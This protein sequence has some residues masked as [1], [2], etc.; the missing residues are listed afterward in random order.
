[1]SRRRKVSKNGRQHPAPKSGARRPNY[2]LLGLALI[3]LAT[4][5]VY[6]PA[7]SGGK[8]IDD[9]GNITPPGLRSIN[10]LYHIWFDPKNTAQ[11][12]PL[13]HTVFWIEHRLWGDSYWSYHLVTLLWHAANV[14]LIYFILKKLRVPGALLAAAFFAL[15]PVIV[16]SVAWMCEQKNTLSTLFYL[17]AMSV[18]LRFD[19]S[20]HP[21]QYFAGLGLFA[22]ALLTKTIT[23]TLPIA[24]LLIFWWQRGTLSW[25]RDVLPLVTFFALGIACG[26]LTV[27]VEQSYFHGEEA[28]F[29]LTP[30]QR[31]LFAGRGIWF[32]LSKLIWPVNLYFTYP[33]WT[34][35]PAQWWQWIY[36]VAAL[37]TTIFLWT[38][39]N[40]WRAP[41]A[42]WLFFCVTLLPGIGLANVYMFT[43]TFVA[44]HMQYL[45]CLGIFVLAAAVLAQG[46]AGLPKSMRWSGVAACVVLVGSLAALSHQQ[47]APYGDAVTYYRML[48]A[49]NPDS[50]LAENNLGM[51]LANRGHYREA[52]EHYRASLRLKPIYALAHRNLGGL[53]SNDRR[54]SEA[55]KEF[56]IA[57]EIAPD[58]PE[59]LYG[60]GLA[61][62]QSGQFK[63]AIEQLERAVKLEPKYVDAHNILGVTLGSA[64]MTKKAI[65]EF[66][67]VLE[68]NSNNADAHNNWGRVL[69]DAGDKPA[70][71]EH[72]Q[73]AIELNPNNASFHFNLASLLAETGLTNDAIT[74]FEQAVRLQPG[75][76]EA[77]PEL[78]KALNA[79]GRPNDAVYFAQLGIAANRNAGQQA[80][81]EQIE[82]WLRDYQQQLERKR[83]T[84]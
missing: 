38:I 17:G 11:Y 47:S 63:E 34:I 44:D 50:W 56:R 80:A 59:A 70:A 60:L 29:T 15:H 65:A 82:K 25:R 81:A 69:A 9:E 45:A 71:I 21:A 74:H 2:E 54:F 64:G 36:P 83:A 27:F 5:W 43:I 16:E 72:F 32:Y 37:V 52:M 49:E 55:I 20:R 14:T 84:K 58:D 23:V 46:F 77:Y 57:L 41:L 78:G 10:G 8:L 48:V 73:Q 53:L 66:R 51:E 61:L 6:M 24:L 33:R 75:F 1:M 68:L 79:A 76:V 31:I 13:L 18:Y 22:M 26:L 12:Y 28:S 30:A 4:C 7:M 42:C 40:R 39:R 35:D 62:S 67:R 3:L 19:A